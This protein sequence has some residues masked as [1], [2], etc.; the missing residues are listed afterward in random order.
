MTGKLKKEYLIQVIALCR[1]TWA[2]LAIMVVALCQNPVARA[3]AGQT[4]DLLLYV[5]GKVL[6][7]ACWL[8]AVT[9]D[10]I[11]V[12]SQWL[13][14]QPVVRDALIAAYHGGKGRPSINGKKQK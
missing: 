7:C 14:N 13:I 12:G 2:A 11:R 1:S 6:M 10:A 5:A 8:L 4:F 9:A 3:L